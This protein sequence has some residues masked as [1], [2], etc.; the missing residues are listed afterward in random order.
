M[1]KSLY[2]T[3]D[4]QDVKA[5]GFD[6]DGTLYDEFDFISQVY[7]P[8]ADKIAAA[9]GSDYSYMY[10]VLLRSWLEK[11][12]SYNRIFSDVLSAA[13]VEQETADRVVGDCLGVFRAFQPALKLSA[14]VAALLAFFAERYPLFL[15]SDG[16]C[17]LQ[18]AKIEAL[19]LNRW[20][21]PE[22][23]VISGCLASRVEKPSTV[24]LDSIAI[25]NDG[26]DP[27]TVVFF[28]DRAVDRLFAEAAGFRFVG[29]KN[30]WAV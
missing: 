16:S 11:G 15:V 20:F 9:A 22:N 8:I 2:P 18:R 25:F 13:K 27:G 30:M 1:L 3:V 7:G 14:R 28:G 23:V 29:V 24:A 10:N 21:R 26:F 17:E 4:W 19:G 6:L 12:S 5:V